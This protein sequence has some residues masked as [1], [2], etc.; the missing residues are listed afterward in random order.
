MPSRRINVGNYHDIIVKRT[1]YNVRNIC[2]EETF[3]VL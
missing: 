3:M 1:H 2:W